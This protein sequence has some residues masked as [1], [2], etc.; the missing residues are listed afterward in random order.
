MWQPT[1]WGSL[2]ILMK[3]KP[4]QVPMEMT[5]KSLDSKPVRL[6]QFR[7]SVVIVSYSVMVC[8]MCRASTG[9]EPFT[10]RTKYNSNLVVVAVS[11]DEEYESITVFIESWGWMC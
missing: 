9:I 5:F 4:S 7:D 1:E 2:A 11:L 10:I 8:A 3:L 6:S